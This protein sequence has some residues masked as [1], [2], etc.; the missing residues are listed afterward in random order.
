MIIN[1]EIKS[2]I[3]ILLWWLFII[4]STDNAN[5]IS[6]ISNNE[7]KVGYVYILKSFAIRSKPFISWITIWKHWRCR[8]SYC[9]ANCCLYR[10]ISGIFSK[11]NKMTIKLTI[12][13]H[14]LI[15]HSISKLFCIF[16]RS[17][18]QFSFDFTFYFFT[19]SL[20]NNFLFSYLATKVINCWY[21]NKDF[22]SLFSKVNTS[23]SSSAICDLSLWEA[24]L[25]ICRLM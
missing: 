5:G 22:I 23:S 1:T 6:I 3:F 19:K 7:K 8:F 13:T 12:N 20:T 4:L 15:N 16:S 11:K 14:S 25:S 9:H 18:T 17:C 10:V 2:I 24:Q 21:P